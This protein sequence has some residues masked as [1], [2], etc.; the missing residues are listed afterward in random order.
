MAVELPPGTIFANDFR[1][2]R[3]LSEGGMGAVFVVEQLSTGAQR[4]LKLMRHEIVADAGLR[5]RFLQEARVGARIASDHVVQVIAAGIDPRGDVPWLAMELL[6]GE[7]VDQR[8]R[9]QGPMSRAEVA[10][11]A[12]QLCHALSAAHAVGVVH[13]DLK[14]NNLFLAASRTAGAP[15]SLKV[16]DFGIAKVIEEAQS[17]GTMSLGTPLWMAPEQTERKGFVGPGTD[18]WAFGLITFFV[19][20]GKPYWLAASEANTGVQTLMREML[21]EPIVPPSRRAAELGA[22]HLIPPGFDDWFMRL[23][24]RDPQRRESQAARALQGLLA[25]L[26]NAPA[27]PGP[28][29]TAFAGPLA[30]TGVQAQSTAQPSM[31]QPP[32]P[33]PHTAMAPGTGGAWSPPSPMPAMRVPP[34]GAQPRRSAM[35][36]IAVGLGALGVLGVGGYFLFS[37]SP[38][39]KKKSSDDDD[40]DDKS[41]KGDKKDNPE[42]ARAADCEKLAAFHKKAEKDVE[43][44][45]EKEDG[46]K[47]TL[48]DIDALAK[49]FDS[50]SVEAKNLDLKTAEA[51]GI[52]NRYSTALASLASATR[53]V[54]AGVRANDEA[55]VQA[56]AEKVTKLEA[57][58]TAIEAEAV[59]MCPGID[60]SDDG[61]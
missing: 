27:Q 50:L 32:V 19:L 45:T 52:A 20:T 57:E 6:V 10:E 23:V 18:L 38:K 22:G 4:A 31:M 40:D 54:A 41:G 29:A 33:G 34:Q 14:P 39:K 5:D 58:L 7:E 9:R 25:V 35:G 13:R 30:F 1:V 16:L 56:E 43:A 51:K 28:Q 11:V 3:P 36:A 42:Q 24:E 8:V 44:H 48:E 61:S 17:T 53:G 47:P 2:V 55:K 46:S 37:G 21:F 60:S 12:K 15:F 49:T 26:Q 59:K